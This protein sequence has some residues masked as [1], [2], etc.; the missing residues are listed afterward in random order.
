[1]FDGLIETLYEL[2]VDGKLGIDE[3]NNLVNNL[4]EYEIEV[5]NS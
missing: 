3:Y 4:V 5:E 2:Y 1:M